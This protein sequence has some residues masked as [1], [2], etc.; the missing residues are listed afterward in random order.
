MTDTDRDTESAG[1]LARRTVLKGAALAGLAGSAVSGSASAQSGEN[2]ITFESAG[3]ETFRYRFSVTGEIERIRSDDGDRFVDEKTVEGAVSQQRLD[4][5]GFTGELR[6]L[7]LSG[8]GRVF[9]ND[10]LVRDTTDPLANR[11]VVE[12]AGPTVRYRFR[13]TGRVEK[14]EFAGDDDTV[15]D[16]KTVEGEVGGEGVD[17]YRYSGSIVFDTP[18]EPLTVTLELNQGE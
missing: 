13:V 4:R 2:T 15:V 6:S 14:D 12:S 3:D 10:E 1:R 7:E 9:V 18:M 11:V 16:S 17:S 8:P 5:F